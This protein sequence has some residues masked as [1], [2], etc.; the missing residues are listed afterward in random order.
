MEEKTMTLA[1]IGLVIGILVLCAGVYYLIKEK[2]DPESRKIYGVISL[3]G[4]ALTIGMI[5]KLIL[6]L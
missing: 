2:S 3:L 6:S 1:I 4:G 5:V